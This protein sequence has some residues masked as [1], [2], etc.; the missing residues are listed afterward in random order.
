[1]PPR[2][3]RPVKKVKKEKK[4]TGTQ[5]KITAYMHAVKKRWEAPYIPIR[6]C[7][8]TARMWKVEQRPLTSVTYDDVPTRRNDEHERDHDVDD[9][10]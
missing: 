8:T 1:M 6:R 5:T 7:R 10:Q 2:T 4:L 9:V 3:L